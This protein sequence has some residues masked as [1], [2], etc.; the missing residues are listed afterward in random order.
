VDALSHGVR[1]RRGRRGFSFWPV[2]L[3]DPR[4][5][6]SFSNRRHERKHF[7]LADLRFCLGP[8]F[9]ST[10]PQAFFCP[11]RRFP[12]PTR[13]EA[14]TAGRRSA[15]AAHSAVSRPRLDSF[16]HGGRLDEHGPEERSVV[17]WGL[18]WFSLAWIDVAAR[19]TVLYAVQGR[20]PHHGPQGFDAAMSRTHQQEIGAGRIARSSRPVPAGTA[21]RREMRRR[22]IWIASGG[23]RTSFSVPLERRAGGP[24][25]MQDDG[26]LAGNRHGCLLSSDAFA[27]GFAPGL[28]RAWSC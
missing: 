25:A 28:Q 27:K 21:L 16:E 22:D 4:A 10:A 3:F 14:V 8:F 5:V 7:F 13:A 1:P 17:E 24:H 20:W 2:S 18:L 12:T 6:S 9:C 23:W 19:S 15:I 11:D 26:K